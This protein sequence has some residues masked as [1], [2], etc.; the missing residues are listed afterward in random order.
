ML[1]SVDKWNEAHLFRARQ[2]HP[3]ETPQRSIEYDSHPGTEGFFAP[4]LRLHD[5]G[6]TCRLPHLE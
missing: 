2:R 5:R 4:V 6:G 3:G 1:N